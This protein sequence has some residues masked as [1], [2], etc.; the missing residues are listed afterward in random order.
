MM[1]YLAEFLEVMPDACDQRSQVT[2]TAGLYAWPDTKSI[3]CSHH[4]PRHP[5]DGPTVHP[6]RTALAVSE[7]AA[8]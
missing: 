2:T 6:P 1:R 8:V 4:P 3:T 7:A 5:T